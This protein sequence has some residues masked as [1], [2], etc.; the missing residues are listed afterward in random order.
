MGR[1][2]PAGLACRHRPEVEQPTADEGPPTARATSSTTT[3]EIWRASRLLVRTHGSEPDAKDP[4]GTTCRDRRLGDGVAVDGA[5]AA[6][7]VGVSWLAS[8]ASKV[9]SGIF[10]LRSK[11]GDEPGEPTAD[12]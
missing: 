2:Q 5:D 8:R 6:L 7:G 3:N 4:L 11:A 12:P 9:G 10:E 1:R